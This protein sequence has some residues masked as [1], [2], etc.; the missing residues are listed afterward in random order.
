M[1]KNTKVVDLT[2]YRHFGR[3][4]KLTRKYAGLKGYNSIM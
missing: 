1:Y 4:E 2:L 3:S